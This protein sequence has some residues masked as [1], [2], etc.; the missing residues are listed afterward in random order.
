MDLQMLVRHRPKT[1]EL[2]VRLVVGVTSPISL[3]D[4]IKGERKAHT[5]VNACLQQLSL[6]TAGL[7][8][9]DE[10][11]ST[12]HETRECARFEAPLLETLADAMLLL[13]VDYRQSFQ[14]GSTKSGM[15]LS[16]PSVVPPCNETPAGIP[17]C[18]RQRH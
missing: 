15:R 17:A 5:C 3:T 10:L 9:N 11:G 8:V 6:F 18:W 2:G 14:L 1:Q 16:S 7:H 13:S 4:M 12:A